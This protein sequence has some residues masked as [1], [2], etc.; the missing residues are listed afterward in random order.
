MVFSWVATSNAA[1]VIRTLEVGAPVPAQQRYVLGRDLYFAGNYSAA[2]AEFRGALAMFPTSPKLA[3]N[4]ARSEERAGRLA[5][6]VE[7]Y[8]IYLKGDI[9]PDDRTVV[10][11]LVESLKARILAEWP[12]VLIHTTPQGARVHVDE[13]SEPVATT[14]ARLRQKPGPHVVVLRLTG[15]ADH[16]AAFELSKGQSKLLEATLQKVESREASSD[17]RDGHWRVPLG[18]GAVALGGLGLAAGS[19]F[20][21]QAAGTIEESG[22]LEANE[23]ARYRGLQEDL[24]REEKLMWTGFGVGATA[25]TIGLLLLLDTFN[26]EEGGH[27]A[28]LSG[29]GRL[30][31]SVAW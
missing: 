27:V 13:A 14:P 9:P 22:T 4:L 30:G 6:A 19:V 24:Q 11:K 1:E 23:R 17:A 29:P 25:T 18:W 20:A 3:F 31:G 10:L 28:W 8:E 12:E 15:Y 26:L 7:A 5:E 21:A 2:A 16:E